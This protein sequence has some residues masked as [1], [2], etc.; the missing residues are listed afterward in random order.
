MAELDVKA[1][2][3]RPAD[4][5]ATQADNRAAVVA[6]LML[7]TG[8]AAI[9][10]TIVATAIPQI[11]ADL[12]GFSL[13]PWIFSIYL[14]TQAVTVPIYGRLSDVFG[15]KPVLLVGVAGFLAGSILCAVAWSMPTL[16]VFRGVQGLAAG[17]ILPTTTTIVGDLYEPAERGRIQGYIS[18]VWGVSAIVGPALGGFFAQ[19][20]TWRG[21]FWLNLPIGVGAA[22]LIQRH[23]HERIERRSHRIDY[24]GAL[25]LTGACSLLIL[26]LLEGGVSWAWSSPAS[27]AL[28]V[29]AT[30]LLVTFV[31]I[32]RTVAEPILP[33]WIFGHRTLLAGNLA[34]LAIGAVLIGQSSY[35]PTYAQRVVGVG[36]VVAGFAMAAMT[37][38]W[39]LAATL[40]PRVYLRIDFRPTALLGGAV[41]TAGCLLLALF[42]GESSGVWRVAVASFVLGIGLGFISVSTV[43]AVQSVVDWG[44]RGV[45]TG[46]NMFIRTLGSAVGI[47][48]FGSIANGRLAHRRQTAP[49]IYQAIHG[50]FWALVAV[51]VLGVAAQLLLPRRVTPLDQ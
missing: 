39:P 36:A 15:R 10:S 4:A 33:L 44:R 7:T 6:A 25:T 12:G 5:S 32:E 45:V 30:M 24:A 8:L 20:W 27:V 18:S 42:V 19:Y 13:F 11:V 14:L 9:D 34:G 29:I 1:G 16:I 47:A 46:S 35:V 43:V 31:L 51:A 37:I 26:A 38:G 28:L 50:V 21:I 23:L 40:A 22:W 2:S 3:R 48:V 49:A 17:A 41:S